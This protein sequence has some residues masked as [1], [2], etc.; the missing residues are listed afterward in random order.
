VA[1][2]LEEPAWN[3][4]LLNRS[5]TGIGTAGG[6]FPVGFNA[7]KSMLLSLTCYLKHEKLENTLRS[8]YALK[9]M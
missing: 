1:Y 2:S 3:L 4:D 9:G 7:L 6:R 5:G 8:P